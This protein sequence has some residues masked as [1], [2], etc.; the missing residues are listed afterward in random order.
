MHRVVRAQKVAASVPPYLKKVRQVVNNAFTLR[1]IRLEY[2]LRKV[3]IQINISIIFTRNGIKCDY[4]KK[5][6]IIKI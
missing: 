4:G 6:F 1:G 2:W 3:P 5:F